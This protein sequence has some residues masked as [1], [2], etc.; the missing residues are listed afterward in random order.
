MFEFGGP[1]GLKLQSEEVVPVPRSHHILV[2]VHACGSQPSRG[3]HSLW[4]LQSKTFLTPHSGL[5]CGGGHR[6]CSRQC[7]RFQERLRDLLLQQSLWW[8]HRICSCSRSHYL[9]TGRDAGLE[10]GGCPGDPLL[11]SL[12]SSVRQCRV[13]AAEGVLVHG[14]SGG[15]GFLATRQIDRAHGLKPWAQLVLRKGRRF[16]TKLFFKRA[17]RVFNH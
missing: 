15:V 1:E 10:A 7:V 4:E 9:P 2:K 16:L 3:I 6:I 14:A 13:Q 8:L 12:P 11:H 5:R 17:H